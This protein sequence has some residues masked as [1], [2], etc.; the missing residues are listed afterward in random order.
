MTISMW[1]HKKKLQKR[2]IL[3]QKPKHLLF[4]SLQSQQEYLIKLMSLLIANQKAET[5]NRCKV[6]GL[7]YLFPFKPLLKQ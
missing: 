2:D 1:N 6:K 7:F 3:K 4:K 5:W